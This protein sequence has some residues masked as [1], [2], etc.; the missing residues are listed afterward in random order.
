MKRARSG[1]PPRAAPHGAAKEVGE[2]FK[3]KHNSKGGRWGRFMLKITWG[4]GRSGAP[5]EEDALSPHLEVAIKGKCGWIGS[6][7]GGGRPS[8]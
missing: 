2:V 7:G 1:A 6:A 5:Q 3:K 8:N 4:E